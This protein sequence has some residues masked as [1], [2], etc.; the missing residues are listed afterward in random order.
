MT[1]SGTTARS[2]PG[3]NGTRHDAP[4]GQSPRPTSLVEPTG[5]LTTGGPIGT[6]TVTDADPNP[7]SH[8]RRAGVVPAR[9]NDGYLDGDGFGGQHGNRDADR[10]GTGHDAAYVVTAP[11]DVTAEATGALT[12]V[13]I[14]TATATD[15]GRP[16]PHSHARRAGVVPAR[17]SDGYLDGDGFGGQHG[18]R[19]ADRDGAVPVRARAVLRTHQGGRGAGGHRNATGTQRAANS[20]RSNAVSS[21][22]TAPRGSTSPRRTMRRNTARQTPSTCGATIAAMP[23]PR[24]R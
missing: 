14:G 1:D 16:E 9:G 10:N 20:L 15:N 3:N 5:Q 23:S 12:T 19:D 4:R 8:E 24:S 11:A 22:P 6:P 13:D 18:N 2:V 21:M 17:G 7:T